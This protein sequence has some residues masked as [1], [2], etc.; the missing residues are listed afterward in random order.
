MEVY[1]DVITGMC[2]YVYVFSFF[3]SCTIGFI[4]CKKVTVP[5]KVPFYLYGRDSSWHLWFLISH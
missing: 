3:L 1:L 5:V 2:V 4:S